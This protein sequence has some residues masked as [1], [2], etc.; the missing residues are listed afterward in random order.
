MEQ[1]DA[2]QNQNSTNCDAQHSQD[3]SQP[4]TGTTV[5]QES[6]KLDQSPRQAC[7]ERP[8]L[9]WWHRIDWSQVVLDLLLLIVGIKLA[10]IYYG[11]LTQ[12]IESNRISRSAMVI[13]QRAFVSFTD[14]IAPT[15]GKDTK[16]RKKAWAVIP[17][18]QNSGNTAA[19][20]F[21]GYININSPDYTD[22]PPSFDYGDRVY[23]EGAF[24]NSNMKG[25][26]GILAPHADTGLGVVGVPDEVLDRVNQGAAHVYL[27]GWVQYD[28]ISGCWPITR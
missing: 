3:S 9:K 10:F 5:A 24:P 16:T 11:Q 21:H 28:D 27:W 18:V 12:M 22:L 23:T 15:G 19:L 7:H 1:S 13:S 17:H 26:R 8:N 4:R 20:N 2:P 6:E 14:N 25:G